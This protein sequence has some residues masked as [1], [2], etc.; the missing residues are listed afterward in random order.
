MYVAAASLLT[1]FWK[2]ASSA[3]APVDGGLIVGVLLLRGLLGGQL[4]VQVELC[5]VHRL[6]GLLGLPG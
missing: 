2:V 1:A 3:L 5:A 6:G 4:L